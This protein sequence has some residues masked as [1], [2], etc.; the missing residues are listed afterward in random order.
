MVM[1]V[2]SGQATNQPEDV[3]AFEDNLYDC[4]RKLG[5]PAVELE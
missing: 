5:C 4:D 1:T 3:I 2:A